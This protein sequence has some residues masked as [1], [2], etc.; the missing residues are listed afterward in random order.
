M[1]LP[2]RNSGI[3]LAA[4]LPGSMISLAVHLAVLV[5]AGMSLR[6]C[7]RGVPVEAGGR[8]YRE[9][10]LAVIPDRSDRN[11][12][13]PRQNP[14]DVEPEQAADPVARL[15]T[16]KSIPTEAPTISELLATEPSPNQ[17]SSPLA[18]AMDLSKTIGPG[19]PIG[20]PATLQGGIPPQIRPAANSGQGS[21]G[22]PT[23]G[24][25]ETQF[26]N[27]IDGGS[28][29]VYV[30]DTSSSMS[31]GRRMGLAKSQLKGSLRLLRPNQKFQVLFYN[32]AITQMKLRRR[33]LQDL[34]VATEVHVQLAAAEI[35]RV[36]PRAGTEH[37][38]PLLRALDLQADV[39][40]FLTDGDNPALS[41]KGAGSDLDDLRRLNQNRTRIH[42]IEFGAG[43][44]ESRRQ[45]WLQL[46]AQQSGGVYKY[47]AVR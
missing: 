26:M 11:T 12:S 4:L 44:R 3:R 41:T 38:G 39:I 19:E 7:D 27:I 1:D 40:Y 20:S 33:T 16:Q 23:P 47:I 46:L 8:D 34:Y 28:S 42:V 31:E 9:V 2:T 36:Q 32:E 15:Q 29:F 17:A 14:H 25:G 43:P 5:V 22:S 45:S 37:K 35:D 30:V 21:A 24:P 6:G 18:V 10:G 13:T